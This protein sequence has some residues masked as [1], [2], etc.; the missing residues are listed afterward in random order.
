MKVSEDNKNNDKKRN[1]LVF[2]LQQLYNTNK[3][4]RDLS[5]KIKYPKS[6]KCAYRSYDIVYEP[7]ARYNIT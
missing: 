1:F 2:K 7:I 6:S 3:N 4:V 5:I